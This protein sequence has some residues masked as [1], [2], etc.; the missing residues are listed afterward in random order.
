MAAFW[1]TLAAFI[2]GVLATVGV[3]AWIIRE[4]VRG[5]KCNHSHGRK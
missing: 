5:P 2:A 3:L 1:L 4:A